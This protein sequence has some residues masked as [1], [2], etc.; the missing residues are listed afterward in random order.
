[1]SENTI[2]AALRRL[3]FGKEEMTGRGFRSAASSI[4]NQCGLCNPVIPLS[5]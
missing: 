4:R 1:M 2:N 3:S 5:V